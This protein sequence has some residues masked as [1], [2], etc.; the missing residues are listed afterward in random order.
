[1]H[2]CVDCLRDPPKTVRPAPYGGPR[3]RRC[4]THQRAHL[5]AQKM[6]RKVRHVEVNF[7]LTEEEYDAILASQGGRCFICRR[8]TG[9][10]RRLAVDHDHSHCSVC[11]TGKA[12]RAGIRALLCKSCNYHL[13][14]R[15]GAVALLRAI[16]VLQDHPAQKIL[17]RGTDA[18]P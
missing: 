10:A 1:M 12:C 8:A 17:N 9:K 4:A 14:G 16:E 18:N 15:Y 5:K 3:S 13:L 11:A 6:R 7:D 2:E